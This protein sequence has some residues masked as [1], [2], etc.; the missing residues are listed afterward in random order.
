M[1]Q[2][3][4]CIGKYVIFMCYEF[5]KMKKGERKIDVKLMWYVIVGLLDWV[6]STPT[7]LINHLKIQL[8]MT[9]KK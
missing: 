4:E 5:K 6:V 1:W 8:C 3:V 2:W 9:A 7:T